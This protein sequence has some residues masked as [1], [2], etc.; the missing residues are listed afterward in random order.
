[1]ERATPPVRPRIERYAWPLGAALLAWLLALSL[2]RR[3][4]A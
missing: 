2:P 3:R 1:V 4:R